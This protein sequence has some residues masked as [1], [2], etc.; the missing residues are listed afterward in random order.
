MRKLIYTLLCL[1][2]SATALPAASRAASFV[3]LGVP[4]GGSGSNFSNALGVSAD[5]SVV[6]G[7][8]NSPNLTQAFR[9]TAGGGMIG[10][11]LLP[12]GSFSFATGVSANGSVVLG[13]LNDSASG[14]Q[15]QETFIWDPILG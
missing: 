3:G 12:G 7:G 11:G 1:A 13:D 10:L 5:S 8:V 14:I 4:T 9:W 6:V 2:I 15:G